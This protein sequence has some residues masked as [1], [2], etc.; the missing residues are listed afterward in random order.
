MD[1]RILD[2]GDAARVSL[3]LQHLGRKAETTLEPMEKISLDMLRVEKAVFDSNG[4]RGGGSWAR[5]KDST[6]ERKGTTE[7][8]RTRGARPGYSAIGNDALYLSVTEKDAP[9]QIRRVTGTMIDFGTELD[10]GMYVQHGTRNMKARPFLKFTQYDINR[11][12]Q[13]ILDHL[14]ST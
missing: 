2:F 13:M 8:L 7:I 10:E 3:R 11:W 4:R 9:F 14:V 6:V 1:F 5:L 12:K